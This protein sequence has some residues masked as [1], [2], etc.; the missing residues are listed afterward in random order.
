MYND[1]VIDVLDHLIFMKHQSKH[2]IMVL[3]SES[4]AQAT[5]S[6]DGETIWHVKGWYNIPVDGYETVELIEIDEFEYK[7]LK[8]LNYKSPEEILDNFVLE[9]VLGGIL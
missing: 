7:S 9:L 4:E 3:C 8:A 6:S 5:L 1:R 2:N